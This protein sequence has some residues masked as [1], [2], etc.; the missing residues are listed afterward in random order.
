M[1]RQMAVE[2]VLTE[3]LATRGVEVERGVRL[4]DAVAE[5]DRA[6]ALLNRPHA[7]DRLECGYVAGCDGQDSTVRAAAGIGWSG[8]PYAEEVLLADVELDGSLTPGVLHAVPARGGL[9]FAFYLGEQAPWRLLATRVADGAVAAYG[10]PGEPV[11]EQDLH[12]LLEASGLDA[13]LRRVAWSARVPLQHR[14][15]DS[16]RTGRLFLAGDAAHA[17][18]PAAAQGMNTGIQDGLNLGWKLAF[19]ARAGKELVELLD[20][21]E[22]ERRAVARLVL[23]LTHAVFFAEAS[24]HPLAQL[25]RAQV[26]PRAAPLVPTLLGQRWLVTAALRVLSGTWVHHRSSP[27]SLEGPSREGPHAGDR[28]PDGRVASD[29]ETA[30]LHEL[31]ARRPGVQVLLSRD[32]PVVAGT[33]VGP[34]VTVVRLDRPGR[35]VSVIRPDGFVGFTSGLADEAEIGSWLDLV[36]A[37]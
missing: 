31:L 15:A 3:A 24:T 2:T 29:G 33:L 10:R 27:I 16:F 6:I 17:H 26:V 19:A 34:H 20:S 36:G 18:S 21:Y 12:D 30:D 13:S 32:A 14:L 7:E 28:L 1:I 35:G 4:V 25:L 9:V 8:A 11:D 37:R 22:R 23:A 5:P